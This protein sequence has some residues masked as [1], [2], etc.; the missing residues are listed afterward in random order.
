MPKI[1]KDDEENIQEKLEYIGLDLNVIPTFFKEYTSLEYRPLKSYEDNGYK[2]YRYLPISKIQIL[3]TPKNRL[4]S[5]QE[6]YMLAAPIY[7]YLDPEKEEDII[8]YTTFLKMLEEVKIE[9]IQEIEQEQ[10][11]LNKQIPFKVKFH[12]NYLW[13]IYYA[14]TTDTYFMLV[15]TE[16]LEYSMLF[17]LLKKQI[18]CQKNN[19]EEVLF[20]PISHEPFSNTYLKKSEFT[21]MEK[22]LWLFTKQWPLIYEVYDKQNNLSIHI[23]GQTACYANITSYYKVILDSK[24]E[25]NKFYKLLKALFILQTE[26]PQVYHFEV[27]ID[28]FGGLEFEYLNK[29]I[30]YDTL[31]EMLNQEYNKARKALEKSEKEITELEIELE[32]LKQKVRTQ[33]GEYL[34]KEKQI[35]TYLVCKRTFLGRVTYFLKEKKKKK[36][37][38]KGVKENSKGQ[39]DREL[40]QE[41][42]EIEFLQKEYYTIEDIVKIQ[43]HLEGQMGKVKKLTLDVQALQDK[44]EYMRLRIK[45]ATLY[46]TEIDDHE[47]SIFEFWKFANKD[48]KLLLN[49]GQIEEEHYKKIEKVFD[50]EEDREEIGIQ[51]DKQQRKIFSK[52]ETDAIYLATTLVRDVW[53]QNKEKRIIQRN[54]ETLKQEAEAERILF[55]SEQFDIFGGMAEDGTKI[56]TLGNQKHRETK[57]DKLKLLDINKNTTVAEYQEKLVKYLKY[58]KSSLDKAKSP[59][60]IPVYYARTQETEWTGLEVFDIRPEQVIKE[61]KEASDTIYLY[62]IY[63]KQNM[64]VIYFSNSIY[65][66]NYNKTLPTGMHLTTKCLIDIERFKLKLRNKTDFRINEEIDEMIIRTKKICVQE[67]DVEVREEDDK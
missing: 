61:T 54:L 50:Y 67:Y 25:V 52:E 12:E 22:Y 30:R 24:E 26:I 14:D 33:E 46:L 19:T 65:F 51:I 21:D 43:K 53:N 7:S 38:I 35:A 2:V 49:R 11:Q 10:E 37:Y 41:K 63:L 31:A 17:Y 44:V 20:A 36:K 29:K 62:K 48:E 66:D 60:S 39:E 58:M 45:N 42:Q 55:N 5:I 59:L 47:K 9:E 40:I 28:N 3:L 8:K 16:D 6:K 56:K 23:V 57:K 64:P 4:N 32:K 15:P 27:K 1:T 34:Q 13:Q 18:K